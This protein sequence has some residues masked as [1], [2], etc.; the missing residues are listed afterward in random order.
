MNIA[1]RVFCGR[2]SSACGRAHRGTVKDGKKLIALLDGINDLFDSSFSCRILT[3]A[4]LSRHGL[5]VILG[6]TLEG[7][8]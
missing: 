2:H 1:I 4:P 8:S 7:S 3:I 5:I 6:S